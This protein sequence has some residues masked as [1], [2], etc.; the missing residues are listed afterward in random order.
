MASTVGKKHLTTP[1]LVVT[2]SHDFA[3]SGARALQRS[4]VDQQFISRFVELPQVEH[5]GV[6]QFALPQVFEFFDTCLQR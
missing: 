2:G 5:M 6:V 3:M 1:F 4:L